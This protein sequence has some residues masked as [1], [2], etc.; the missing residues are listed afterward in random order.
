ME[1][2]EAG[3]NVTIAFVIAERLLHLAV[4]RTLPLKKSHSTAV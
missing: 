3:R 1:E 2:P 4:S